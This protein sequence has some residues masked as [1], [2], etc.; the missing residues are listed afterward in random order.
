MPTAVGVIADSHAEGIV[1]GTTVLLEPF[2]NLSSW[3]SAGSPTPSIVA[4]RTGTAATLQG[5][6]GPTLTYTIPGA[7]ESASLTV[8]FA[9]KMTTL[10]NRSICEFRSDAAATFHNKLF[11][12]NTSGGLAVSRAPSTTLASSAAGVV[13]ADTWAYI[14]VGIVLSDT[15]GTV[16]VK[17]NGYTVISLSAQ[18]TRNAGTKAVYDSI[19]LTAPGTVAVDNWFDDLYVSTGTSNNFKG[20]ITIP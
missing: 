15:V 10:A 13:A 14:E 8:G 6:A 7:N 11:A 19:R 1:P 18:D 2:N 4:G 12:F 20:N 5:V 17:V 9:W 16:V 3:A